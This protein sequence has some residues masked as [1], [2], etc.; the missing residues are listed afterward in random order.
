MTAQEEEFNPQA[1]F[2]VTAATDFVNFN[3]RVFTS[4]YQ[5]VLGPT[6]FSLFYALRAQLISQ[7][8]LA[9]R[10]LQANII[11]QLNAGTSQLARALHRLEAVGMVQTYRG[12]DS[13]GTFFVYQLRATLT[14]AAFIE[15]DLLSVL[16]LEAVGDGH[17]KQLV[18]EARRYQLAS[19]PSLENVSH[20]FLDEFHVANKS[21]VKTPTTIKDAREQTN[22]DQRPQLGAGQSDF[23]WPT[24]FQLVKK[25]PVMKKDLSAARQLIEVEHQLY[26]IDEP[27]MAKLVFKAVDLADNH[28]N[29]AKFKRIVASRYQQVGHQAPPATANQSASS[30]VK[31]TAKDRQLLQSAADY[32]PVE[33]LQG[34]KEQT[35]GFVSANERHILTHL[36][37]DVKL[38]SAVINILSWY[39]IADLDNANLKASFVD[40]IANSWI[41]AGV[42]DAP[43]A[44]QELK[45]FQEQRGKQRA[46]SKGRFAYRRPQVEEQMP[47]WSKTDSQQLNKKASPAALKEVQAMLAKRK[48]RKGGD[49]Q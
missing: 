1:G 48:G 11:R 12:K 46:T 6:A 7:P 28:F 34:L 18:K 22:V 42:K 37:N 44:L 36:V 45:N 25:Q 13:Q 39:V 32:A 9:D 38:D 47:K 26:G 17:F 23:D 30:P 29:P 27:T 16:L 5:P 21:L 14:P 3:D 40:A 8:T 41:K 4:F 20:H 15:D 10:R 43:G 31:L 35:G 2:L 33:F 49:Q 24:L 19:A